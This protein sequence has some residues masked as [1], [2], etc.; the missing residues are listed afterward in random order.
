MTYLSEIPL[1]PLRR[2]TQRLLRNPQRLH[3]AVMASVPYQAENGRS[4]WRLERRDH[5]ADLLVLSPLRPSWDHLVE[6]CGWPGA[7]G[8]SA[9][10]LG[11]EPLLDRLMVGRRF[12]F[13]LT[14]NPVKSLP[15]LD[16][17]TPRQAAK[18]SDPDRARNPRVGQRTAQYQL[19]WF[20]SRCTGGDERWGFTVGTSAGPA[21]ALVGRQTL[22]FTRRSGEPPVRLNLA[23]F[24]GHLAV[25]DVNLMRHSLLEGIGSGK[26]YG[27]GLLTLARP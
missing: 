5:R 20:L 26:A 16:S 12:R 27:C 4:L 10:I 8:G 23:T 3:A 2:D 9:K 25:T 24:E 18:L 21:V 22:A 11:Y 7:D 1:N 19:E 15:T 13:R 17:P 14:A 6:T